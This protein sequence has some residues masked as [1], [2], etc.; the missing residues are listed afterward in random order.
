[1]KQNEQRRS[2]GRRKSKYTHRNRQVY[3]PDEHLAIGL[4]VGVH[5][6]RGEVKIELH[7][8]FPER[9]TTG[10]L[11]NLGEELNQAEV[12]SARMHKAHMLVRFVGVSRREEAEA[13]R[14]QWIFI[15]ESEANDLDEDIYWIH[16]LVGLQV[17]TIDD[18]VLGEISDVLSTGAN[19]VYLVRTQA[20]FNRGRDLLLPAIA[21]VVQEV[22]ITEGRMIVKLP[23][24]LVE[25]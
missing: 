19:D 15:H 21:D 24:G 20:P 11:L 6:L 10:V 23:P 12:A 9:F 18:D 1:M 17:R 2:P 14:G 22:D 7:T 5:G 13:L 8:D 25:A 16:D 3:I 4:I